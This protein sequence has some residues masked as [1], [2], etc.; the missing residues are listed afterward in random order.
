MRQGIAGCP[1]VVFFFG[2]HASNLT[3]DLLLFRKR[4]LTRL[5]RLVDKRPFL[6]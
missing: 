3:F 1:A 2:R 4:I 5:G 6:T